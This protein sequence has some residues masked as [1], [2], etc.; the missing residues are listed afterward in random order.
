MGPKKFFSSLPDEIP[1]PGDQVVGVR[2][3]NNV[4][5]DVLFAA[6]SDTI[7][8]QI[9][10]DPAVPGSGLNAN[11]TTDQVVT[12]KGGTQFKINDIILFNAS[13][14]MNVAKDFEV[15]TGPNRTGVKICESNYGTEGLAYLIT[16]KKWIGLTFHGLSDSMDVYSIAP[17]IITV[18]TLYLSFGTPQGAAAYLDVIIKATVVA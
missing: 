6:P 10:Q 16:S 9:R 12:L 7:I 4:A 5:S 17:E 2:Y 13:V 3:V 1:T 11:I 18:N 8:A 14:N 15:W